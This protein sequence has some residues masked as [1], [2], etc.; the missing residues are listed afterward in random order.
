MKKILFII[1]LLLLPLVVEAQVVPKAKAMLTFNFIRYIGWSEEVRQ[2]D[3]V[4]GVIK[5]KELASWLT[6][7]STGK[8]FGYQD[9]VIK[10]FKSVDELEDCQVVYV[11]AGG[12]YNKNSDAVMA[13]VGK[14]TL[15]ITEVEG[16][17]N[18]GAMINFVVRDDILKFELHKKNASIA[19]IQFSSKLEMMNGAINL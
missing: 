10:E 5:D 7:L 3:F 19:G 16:A 6:K 4:I 13:K 12:N 18:K 14:N 1:T 2:G 8:K 17:T 15:I 11:G 9:I